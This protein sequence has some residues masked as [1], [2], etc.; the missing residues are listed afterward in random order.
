MQTQPC[1]RD[2]PAINPLSGQL[3]IKPIEVVDI[4]YGNTAAG[5]QLH[6]IKAFEAEAER[7][8]PL[9]LAINYAA[10][11]L[12]AGAAVETN[13]KAPK[14]KLNAII[15]IYAGSGDGLLMRIRWF[16]QPSK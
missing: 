14:P 16:V 12:T 10:K 2:G 3:A 11:Y 8:S 6:K 4:D 1:Q 5:V 9:H 13:S 15:L 7:F